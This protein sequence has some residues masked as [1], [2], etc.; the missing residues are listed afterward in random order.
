MIGIS[1]LRGHPFRVPSRLRGAERDSGL[2]AVIV[3]ITST[4]LLGVSAFAVDLGD[5]LARRATLEAVADQAARSG[6]QFLPDSIA[7]LT[8]AVAVLCAPGNRD[9]GWPAAVCTDPSHAWT[10]DTDLSNGQIQFFTGDANGNGRFDDGTDPVGL[11]PSLN[12]ERIASPGDPATAIRVI[13]PPASVPFGLGQI[14][15][16]SSI[17]VAARSDAQ[18]RTP[19]STAGNLPFFVLKNSDVQSGQFCMLPF[20]TTS[21]LTFGNGDVCNDPTSIHGFITEPRS[22]C[23]SCPNAELLESS[24]EDGLQAV[25]HSYPLW[26]CLG[27]TSATP[28]TAGQ[29]A[30]TTDDDC[31]A[32]GPGTVVQSGSQPANPPDVNCISV[33]SAAPFGGTSSSLR[34]GLMNTNG[35]GRLQQDPCG[36][37]VSVNRP[38]VSYQGVDNSDL[39]D[40]AGPWLNPAITSD[41]PRFLAAMKA[42]ASGQA[43]PNV[44]VLNGQPKPIPLFTADIFDCPRFSAVPV[45]DL[46]AGAT[47]VVRTMSNSTPSQTSLRL[48]VVGFRYMWIG[49]PPPVSQPQPGVEVDNGLIWIDQPLCGPPGPPGSPAP[50]CTPS[51]TVAGIRGYVFDASYLPAAPATATRVG[52]YLGP[53]LASVV[54]LAHDATDPPT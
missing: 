14:F 2:V 42:L 9:P 12:D 52:P 7:A 19:I 29:S 17:A 46:D 27:S 41:P 31:A 23:M 6:A 38:N 28:C 26:P 44:Q 32:L 3:A 34:R 48:P 13:L 37:P 15:G 8:H 5:A 21:P 22:D 1:A 53:D 33:G 40:P 4:V 24:L 30:V 45:L 10:S 25:P 54:D 20:P 47:G 49:S 11:N 36:R 35:D 43:N 18:I 39:F 16:A 50:P 51:M